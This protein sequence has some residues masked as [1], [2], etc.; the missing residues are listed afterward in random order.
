MS[1]EGRFATIDDA[2]LLAEMNR[3][4]IE[5]EGHRNAMSLEQLQARMLAW[6]AGEYRAVVFTS[7][8]EKAGYALFRSET[9]YLYLRQF[10]ITSER[11]RKGLGRAAMA[12]LRENA[13]D[14]AVRIR[15]DVLIGNEAGIAFW[16]SVGFEDYCLTMELDA[17]AMVGTNGGHQTA[18][19]AD[20]IASEAAAEAIRVSL[21]EVTAETVRRV[22]DLSVAENQRKFVAGN[23][24]SLAE[25]LF[26]P[27][28]WYRAIYREDEPVGFVMLYDESLRPDPPPAPRIGLWRFMIDRRYQGQG[29]GR[30]A[31]QQVVE[32]VRRRGIFGSLLVSYVPGEG[33][34]ERFYR[35]FGFRPT[36]EIDDGEIVLELQLRQ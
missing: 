32:H 24:V 35:D 23:A 27:E 19:A 17:A 13:L 16:R 9:E 3:Q 28:A 34:P 21:R 30:A 29:V 8:G 26:S 25:A 14:G 20:R 12:W 4:L 18:S 1:I 15:L 5:D 7:E 22:T 31:L 10:F 36:G 2:P 11:R 6:L 33:S